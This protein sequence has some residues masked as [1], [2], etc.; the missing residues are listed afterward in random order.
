MIFKIFFESVQPGLAFSI[1]KT[2]KKRQRKL[3]LITALRI[4]R[5]CYLNLSIISSVT[6]TML[7]RWELEVIQGEYWYTFKR[8]SSFTIVLAPFWKRVYSKRGLPWK[9]SICTGSKFF[10]FRVDPFKKKKKKKKKK[11]IGFTGKRTGV[12]NVV[13]NVN[14]AATLTSVLSP[15][16]QTNYR[17]S[18]QEHFSRILKSV[19]NN[20]NKVSPDTYPYFFFISFLFVLARACEI[21]RW[22]CGKYGSPG[23][24]CNFTT[25]YF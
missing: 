18:E 3:E 20:S 22:M 5:T 23:K 16:I 9:E 15:L 17:I 1:A 19:E 4:L 10:S 14:F 25:S 6:K 13:S 11:K 24:I 7:K 2:F 8:G 21:Q 12:T